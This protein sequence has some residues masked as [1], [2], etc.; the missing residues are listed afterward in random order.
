M[1]ALPE[2]F[3]VPVIDGPPPYPVDPANRR[4]VWWVQR[5]TVGTRGDVLTRSFPTMQEADAECDR[6]NAGGTP[7]AHRSGIPL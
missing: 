3:A 4:V 1:T 6:L 5:Y 2:W 7:P